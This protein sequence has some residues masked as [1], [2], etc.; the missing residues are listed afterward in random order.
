MRQHD[1][2]TGAEHTRAAGSTRGDRTIAHHSRE[3]SPGS[4]PRG[5]RSA[6]EIL[7]RVVWDLIVAREATRE[8]GR[9]DP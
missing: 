2:A 3:A 5:M 6:R 7:G 8:A 9:E 4:L 1:A